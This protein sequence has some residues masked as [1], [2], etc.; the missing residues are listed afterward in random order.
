MTAKL[1][2]TLGQHSEQGRKEENQDFHGAV[3]PDEPQLKN[4]GIAV[5]IADGVSSCLAGR[6]AAV[7]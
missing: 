6:E 3:I 1:N 7:R 2:I 4:K 5:A